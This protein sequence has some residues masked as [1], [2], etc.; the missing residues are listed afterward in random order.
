MRM[1][2]PYVIPL[3][4]SVVRL[5]SVLSYHRYVHYLKPHFVFRQAIRV[6]LQLH[7]FCFASTDDLGRLRT[8]SWG[9]LC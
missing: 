5:S 8:E 7:A 4:C 3:L 2:H 9:V 1:Q 6:T